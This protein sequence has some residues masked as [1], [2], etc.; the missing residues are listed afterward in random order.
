VLDGEVTSRRWTV[1][2]PV[3]SLASAKS[4]MAEEYSAPADLAR[5]FLEDVLAAIADTAE[6][7][8]I[9]IASRDPSVTHIA[10][11]HGAQIIDDSGHEGINAAVTW[12]AGFAPAGTR[13]AVVVSDLPR[14]T[15][16]SLSAAL[17]A[18]QEHEVAF[19]ADA[20]GTG[21]TM[22]MAGSLSAFPPHFGANSRA[23]HTAMGAVDL[24]LIDPDPRV[25]PARRDADTL[26]ALT[27]DP[28]TLG[29]HTGRL[30]QDSRLIQVNP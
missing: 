13:I 29:P 16:D 12:A 28:S 8:Q 5:A 10:R 11:R 2:V 17:N 9:L 30:V 19:L 25:E 26:D 14:L 21:T 1:I 27:A 22:W 20:E 24:A 3:K 6:V 4:R 15:S 7:E 23:A 18:A